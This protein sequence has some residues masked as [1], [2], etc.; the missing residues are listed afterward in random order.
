MPTV[1]H[2][3]R[4]RAH[5]EIPMDDEGKDILILDYRPGNITERMKARLEEFQGRDPKSLTK[6]ERNR[7]IAAVNEFIL[8]VI[9]QWNLEYQQDEEHPDG[10]VIPLTTEGLKYVPFDEKNWLIEQVTAEQQVGEE[11]GASKSDLS[12]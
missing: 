3:V 11:N 5:L 7:S 6:A 10:G 2:L 1:G 4:N 9:E 12:A 8:S